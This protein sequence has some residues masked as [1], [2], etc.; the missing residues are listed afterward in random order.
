VTG[1][2]TAPARSARLSAR[3]AS[4]RAARLSAR[5]S[6]CLSARLSARAGS[7][8]AACRSGQASVELVGLLPVLAVVAL[9]VAQFLAARSA[10]EVA[11]GAA[12]RGAIA[13]VRGEDARAAARDGLPAWARP[14]A[15]VRVD[16]RQVVVRVRPRG[17]L[18]GLAGLLV[19]EERAD[20]GP[21]T[22]APADPSPS[23]GVEAD[24]LP[25]R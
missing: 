6:A 17:V 23:S 24:R 10:S 15:S 1:G 11:G 7:L 19:A 5:L 12:E 20:A 9:G 25:P 16:R 21:S 14:R 2:A 13:L 3:A 8:R 22:A 4:L 18:P